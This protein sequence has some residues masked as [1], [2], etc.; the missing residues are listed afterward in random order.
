MNKTE[1]IEELK[2]IAGT[3]S[4]RHMA[5]FDLNGD[6]H[7][8][9]SFKDINEFAFS[10]DKDL[11]FHIAKLAELIYK[12]DD[13]PTSDDN[14]MREMTMKMSR[15]ELIKMGKSLKKQLANTVGDNVIKADFSGGKNEVD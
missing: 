10:V 15:D 9:K 11:T 3:M 8:R 4:M 1:T 5:Y 13:D 2:R 7:A 14:I 6:F 12:L